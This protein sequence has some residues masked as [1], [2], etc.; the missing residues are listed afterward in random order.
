MPQHA[1]I[2]NRI[3]NLTLLDR[4]LNTA[5][6]N[7]AFVDK[8]PYYEQSELLLNAEVRQNIAW[9]IEEINLRQAALSQRAVA[10]WSFPPQVA[11][12]DAN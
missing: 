10:I 2:V 5:A 4:R 1:S 6:K 11:D 9:R 3:G 12:D 7:A 8:L